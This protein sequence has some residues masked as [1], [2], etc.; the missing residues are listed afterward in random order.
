MQIL[1]IR[2]D[3]I[4]L[5]EE[6]YDEQDRLVKSLS[7]SGIR[8]FGGKLFPE[9]WKMQKKGEKNR[10]TLLEYRELEFRES[11]P[12]HLFTPSSLRNPKSFSR[13]EIPVKTPKRAAQPV[14]P[15]EP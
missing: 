3:R 1:R 7:C 5:S 15:G 10:Y 9:V 6:F 14:T 4:L 11:L 13:T 8:K 12:D 2:E